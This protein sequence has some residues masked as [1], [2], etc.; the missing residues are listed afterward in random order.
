MRPDPGEV[1]KMKPLLTI[2]NPTEI[3]PYYDVYDHGYLRA[4][5]HKEIPDADIKAYELV[6]ILK[7]SPLYCYNRQ[8]GEK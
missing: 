7:D 2:S 8:T 6:E 1:G 4:R 5:F 3:W